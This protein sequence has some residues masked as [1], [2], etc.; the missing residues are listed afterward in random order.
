LQIALQPDE[1]G[2]FEGGQQQL[3]AQILDLQ[4]KLGLRGRIAHLVNG[5]RKILETGAEVAD[6]RLQPLALDGQ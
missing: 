4:A 1:L 3:A 5:A 6:D 2:E